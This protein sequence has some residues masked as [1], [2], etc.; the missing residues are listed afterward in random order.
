MADTEDDSDSS[1]DGQ[2]GGGGKWYGKCG[3]RI[4]VP[5]WIVRGERPTEQDLITVETR[6][7]FTTKNS[8]YQKKV[9]PTQAKKEL[10]DFFLPFFPPKFKYINQIK[11][12]VA[13]LDVVIMQEVKKSPPTTPEKISGVH[14]DKTQLKGQMFVIAPTVKHTATIKTASHKSIDHIEVKTAST[15]VEKERV[16]QVMNDP[17]VTRL[18]T[19]L[20]LQPVKDQEPLPF[21][22]E[23][24]IVSVHEVGSPEWADDILN[25]PSTRNIIEMQMLPLALYLY[26]QELSDRWVKGEVGYFASDDNKVGIEM[27]S[28]D[29]S[30]GVLMGITE[31]EKTILRE[32]ALDEQQTLSPLSPDVEIEPLL[33]HAVEVQVPDVPEEPLPK[34]SNAPQKSSKS[35]GTLVE[36]KEALPKKSVPQ[37]S[38]QDKKSFLKMLRK[39]EEKE[40]MQKLLSFYEEGMEEAAKQ[41]KDI[42]VL[43]HVGN[44][45]KKLRMSVQ[46]LEHE[47]RQFLQDNPG[48]HKIKGVG[49][50]VEIF[51]LEAEIANFSSKI[52]S[53]KEVSPVLFSK[54][55]AA[56]NN[57]MQVQWESLFE[58]GKDPFS[59]QDKRKVHIHVSGNLQKEL[60]H[61]DLP[62]DQI[63]KSSYLFK[64]KKVFEIESSDPRVAFKLYLYAKSQGVESKLT[65]KTLNLV[66]NS[67][68]KIKSEGKVVS[69]GELYKRIEGQNAEQIKKSMDGLEVKAIVRHKLDHNPGK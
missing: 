68:L 43:R 45:N 13:S 38:I 24:I 55:I 26:L 59:E 30:L 22:I 63:K 20:E 23:E 33:P 41:G 19:P 40:T 36:P 60:E 39:L 49:L 58:I 14:S 25:H 54:Q 52:I 15:A 61:L 17:K 28:I 66:E 42:S 3:L 46:R 53:G 1:A 48:Y 50:K 67:T 6:T 9:T 37:V 44:R 62:M 8:T 57:R 12:F 10:L 21:D 4:K 18:D 31:A 16:P 5:P 65:E 51:E 64:A 69:L 32:I 35:T 7:G 11:K 56:P 2:G 27:G 34:A 29:S 47:T